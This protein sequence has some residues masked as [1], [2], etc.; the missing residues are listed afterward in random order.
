MPFIV[1]S[2]FKFVLYLCLSVY[3]CLF[4]C[5]CVTVLCLFAF[6]CICVVCL[7]CQMLIFGGCLFTF[8]DFVSFRLVF[9]LTIRNF[10]YLLSCIAAA[11]VAPGVVEN[12]LS[13]RVVRIVVSK[14]S[15]HP[16]QLPVEPR[17]TFTTVSLVSSCLE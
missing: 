6:L 17:L 5:N 2:L 15:F 10:S 4:L 8:C 1:L 7:H 14:V 9:G 16:L 13:G 12:L 11:G 3:S